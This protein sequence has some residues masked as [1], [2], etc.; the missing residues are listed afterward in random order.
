MASPTDAQEPRFDV[1]SVL[2]HRS[3]DD[4]MF[5]LQFQEGGRL[6]VT[7]TLRML[8]RTAYGLQEF[9]V[10]GARGWIDDEQFDVDARAGRDSTRDRDLHRAV[11][12]WRAERPRRDDDAPGE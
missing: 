12:R 7:G 11:R 2:P 8:I 3:V 10:V 4:V 9:Q 5:A 1:A 6:T